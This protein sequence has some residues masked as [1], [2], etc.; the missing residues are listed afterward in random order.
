MSK[1]GTY[2]LK[3]LLAPAAAMPLGIHRF[4]ARWIG[5]IA[6]RFYR[7][8]VVRD[9]IAGAFPD[10]SEQ[11]REDILRDFYRHFGDIVTETIWF[12]GCHSYKRLQ[13]AGIVRIANPEVLDD[14]YNSADSVML[15]YT[16]AGNWELLG[17][18]PGYWPEGMC[19]RED[20][21][22][23]VYKKMSSPSWDVVMNDNRKAPLASK[24]T[25]DGLIESQNLIRYVL[26]HRGS[27]KIYSINTDQRPYQAAKGTMV[28]DFMGRE[29]DSM[30]AAAT[31]AAK[32]GF[33]VVFQHMD[34]REDG[35]Y[36]I[37]Y[38]LICQDAS[39]VAPEE[40]MRQYYRL[41]EADIRR[42]PANYLWTHKR[43]KRIV[44]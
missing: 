15:M 37:S 1:F 39:K 7:T 27:K 18:M 11:E 22:C 25:Y 23:A 40:I 9:N 30:V 8:S 34:R 19:V 24:A 41:L 10:L 6:R 26:T 13:R 29:C 38:E 5:V 2:A 31:L 12:G 44:R 16:H 17:G 32:F 28:V 33:P 3:A 20:N 4:N 21:Y 14:A 35:G 43:W 42:Q 36:T